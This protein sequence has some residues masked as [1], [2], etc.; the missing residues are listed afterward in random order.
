[1]SNFL[2]SETTIDIAAI[3]TATITSHSGGFTCFEGW[4]RDHHDGKSVSSLE[5]SSYQILAEKEGNRIIAEAIEKFEIDRAFCTHRVGHLQIGDIAVYVAVSSAHRDA[6]FKACRFIID[7]IKT[8]V[9]IWKKE[10]Y[11]NGTTDW[12]HCQGCN[13]DH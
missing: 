9:P 10:H 8:R 3:R 5:Y 7:E 13:H 2:I 6:A 11:Q 1:M 4:V 12:P